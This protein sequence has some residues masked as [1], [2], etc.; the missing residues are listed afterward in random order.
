MASYTTT[1]WQMIRSDN[2]VKVALNPMPTV[3][4]DSRLYQYAQLPFPNDP[5]WT[6]APTK[7]GKLNF[8][9]QSR[10]PDG[11]PDGCFKNADFTYFRTYVNIPAGTT[12]TQFNAVIAQVDDGARIYLFNN[13]NVGGAYNPADDGKLNGTQVKV[14]FTKQAV[15]GWNMVCIVQ[16]DNCPVRNRLTGGVEI[17]LNNDLVPVDPNAPIPMVA[18][19]PPKFTMETY[20]IRGQGRVGDSYWIGWNASEGKAGII[21]Q[22]QDGVNGSYIFQIERVNVKDGIALKVLNYED[23]SYYLPD[24]TKNQ[25]VYTVRPPMYNERNLATDN[26]ANFLSLEAVSSPDAYLRHK[27]LVLYNESGDKTDN[28]YSQDCTWKFH[29][30]KQ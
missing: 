27:H 12:I 21:T 19:A 3:L 30:I 4:G 16:F 24:L 2:Y 14:D 22:S 1:R 9:E 26:D 20:G 6:D 28:T 15:P 17:R 23:G 29:E 13:S 18:F 25:T 7:D 11:F 5:K 10:L 8:D